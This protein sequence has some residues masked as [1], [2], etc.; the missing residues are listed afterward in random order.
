MLHDADAKHVWGMYSVEFSFKSAVDDYG[1]I[2]SHRAVD[3][4]LASTKLG[5][6]YPVADPGV[7]DKVDGHS[8]YDGQLK[9][10]ICDACRSCHSILSILKPV[11]ANST[12]SLS[13]QLTQMP[14]SPDLVIFVSMTTTTTMAQ[15][16]T[17]PLGMCAG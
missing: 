14:R 5:A 10:S 17:L 4:H 15:P 12:D 11:F 6:T 7:V 9:Y 13:L 16:I 1:C 3:Q 2:G 8:G